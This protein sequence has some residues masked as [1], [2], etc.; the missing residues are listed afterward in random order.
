[1]SYSKAFEAAVDH[2]ML[3]EVGG[4][5]KLTPEVR[6]GLCDTKEQRRAVGYTNDPDD[7]GGETK[8]GVAGNANTDLNIRTLDW[9]GAMA[10]YHKRYWLAGACDKLP[11]RLAVL[12]FDGCVNN[13][14]RR[15]GIFLQRAVGVSPDGEVGPA[16]LAKVRLLDE[17]QVCN[18]VCR[19]REQFYRDIVAVKPVQ[20]KY[21]NGWLRRINE[22][23]TFVT[24][25]PTT[26]A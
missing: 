5:W 23:Q 19:F 14:I 9:D 15:A 7:A 25:L 18:T 11:P 12:H 1:M 21:L 20:A 26:L 16:S 4:F 3:Y 13:G 17:L 22:M 10:V 2:A 24:N 8:F 6:A